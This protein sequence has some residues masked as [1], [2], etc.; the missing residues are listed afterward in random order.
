MV[1]GQAAAGTIC[2]PSG[3]AGSNTLRW[4]RCGE[5]AAREARDAAPARRG[6]VQQEVKRKAPAERFLT[7]FVNADRANGRGGCWGRRGRSS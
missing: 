4:R 2:V 6:R 7:P 5:G 3:H 1:S